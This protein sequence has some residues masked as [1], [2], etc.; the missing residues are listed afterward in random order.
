MGATTAVRPKREV[1]R[2]VEGQ[3]ADIEVDWLEPFDQDEEERKQR[4]LEGGGQGGAPDQD[5]RRSV[6]V[7]ILGP[8][9]PGK[10]SRIKY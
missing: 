5:E 9:E 2:E 6:E 4:E 10:M 8:G 7:G 1:S 3:V